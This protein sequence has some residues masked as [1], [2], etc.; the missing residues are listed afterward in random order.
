ME[1]SRVA[2]IPLFADLPEDELA[3][4][5]SV[6]SEMEI[7]SGQALSGE[8]RIGHSLFAIESGTADVVIGGATVRTIGA[9][10]GVGEIAVLASPPDQ[11]APPE[12]AEGGWRTAS[13]V[14]TSPMRL[15]TLFK[16]DVW[17]LDR[18]AP[19]ATQRLRAM[20]D[21]HRAQDAQR[22]LAKKPAQEE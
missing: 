21:E 4:V 19:V 8:G 3:A 2:A 10:D 22:A 12:V 7:A 6:A 20:V 18:R 9:G 5:A 16:R 13:V 17:A 11:F 14:A 15:I 1:S